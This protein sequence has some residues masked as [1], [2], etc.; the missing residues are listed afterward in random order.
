MTQDNT[1]KRW[2]GRTAIIALAVFSLGFLSVADGLAD[3]QT[4]PA[5]VQPTV[6]ARPVIKVP[7]GGG[8]ELFSTNCVL[9]HKYDGRGG[10]SEGG[11]AADLRVTK[12]SRDEVLQT[13]TNGR[14]NK[15]MPPFKGLLD[16]DMIETLATFVK[17]D[18]KLKE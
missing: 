7:R 3:E 17:E 6:E 11:Y 10:P 8:R 1:S 16:P 15:G 18:L 4:Q 12:L 14:L 13:I 2:D 9:C 5:Q